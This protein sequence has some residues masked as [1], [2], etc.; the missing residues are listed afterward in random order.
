[1]ARWIHKE[2]AAQA[3]ITERQLQN[4]PE[5]NLF[6]ENVNLCGTV[7]ISL[8]YEIC[9]TLGGKGSSQTILRQI[10]LTEVLRFSWD[11]LTSTDIISR[12]LS[13]IF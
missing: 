2:R 6:K 8:I 3:K 7:S 5:Q 4:H 10:G 12:L 1:M 9:T 11:S 13:V